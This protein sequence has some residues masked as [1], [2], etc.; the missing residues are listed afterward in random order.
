MA[1]PIAATIGKAIEGAEA[2]SKTEVM[3]EIIADAEKLAEG[4]WPEVEKQEVDQ[5]MSPD[6][7]GREAW[8]K[9]D[10]DEGNS[11]FDVPRYIITRNESLEN[12]RHPIT[13]VWF[14]RRIIELPDGEK[15]EGVF[16]R[17][18]SVFD[19]KIPEYLYL[20]PDRVQFRECNRQLGM[21]YMMALH[22]MDMY[23]T[24]TQKPENYN[25]WILKPIPT[26]GIPVDAH[27]GAVD[28]ITDR[29][30]DLWILHGNM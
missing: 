25:L 30:R 1:I 7:I 12:D 20:Q 14:E 17:F 23:G 18:E 22:L 9:V 28:Q 5:P 10:V 19:A 3:N 11:Y 16:P 29:R 26:R 2:I 15:I 4:L 13:G 8:K 21:V 6:D 24:T 27:Y